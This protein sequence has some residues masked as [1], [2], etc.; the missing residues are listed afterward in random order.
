MTSATSCLCEL[1]NCGRHRCAEEKANQKA[2]EV[3]QK[4]NASTSMPTSAYQDH[5]IAQDPLPRKPYLPFDTIH[6]SMA[7][8]SGPAASTSLYDKYKQSEM[9]TYGAMFGPKKNNVCP[10]TH[11]TPPG[12]VFT[13]CDDR[14]HRCFKRAESL[15]KK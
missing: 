8:F 15:W 3:N 10:A 13:E 7:H 2:N 4:V 11:S 6:L 14:G 12:F 9:T 5:F 1:C